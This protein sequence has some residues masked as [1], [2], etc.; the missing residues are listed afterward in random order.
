MILIVDNYDSFTYN[1]IQEVG[2]ITNRIKVVK[3]DKISNK[4]IIKSNYSHIIISPGP[5]SPVNAG[6]SINIIKTFYKDRILE[7]T[8]DNKKNIYLS[9]NKT[10]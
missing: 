1:I 2:I 6:E 4:N 10:L 5:G 8:L 7:K 9:L 3:N